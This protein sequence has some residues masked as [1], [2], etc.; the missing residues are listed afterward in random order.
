MVTVPTDHE[1]LSAEV[2][3]AHADTWQ[4]QGRL[5]TAFGGG[6]VILPGISLMASGIP[7][8]QWN[9]G[10][11]IDA[12]R[13][14]MAAVR[15]WYARRADG[16]GV[17]WGVRVPLGVDWP[18]GR[19]VFAQRCMALLPEHFAPVL[20]EQRQAARFRIATPEDLDAI[21]TVDAAA[22][23][24]PP[25][26]TRR[27]VSPQLGAVGFTTVVAAVD[28][29]IVGVATG[30]ATD[31]SAG[32]SVGIFGVCVSDAMRRRGIGATLTSWLVERA[33]ATGARL[34]HLNPNTEEAA[35]IYAR[36][37][38]VETSGFN[39]FSGDELVAAS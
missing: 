39:I 3:A 4:L 21:V 33:L 10:D 6:A 27:W 13:I 34:V 24:D 16:V 38:F 29:A 25:E 12:S 32:P 22:F 31:E 19:F 26:L 1:K 17:P 20:P 14:D 28:D 36:L 30:V 5:R 18:Y 23:E 37:G 9:N 2:R 7:A 8:P 11:V 15:D 35:R